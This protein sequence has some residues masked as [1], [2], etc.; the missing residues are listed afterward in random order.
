MVRGGGGGDT[1][2]ILRRQYHF[3][4]SFERGY[5]IKN[6]ENKSMH[7]GQLNIN[8]FTPFFLYSIISVMRSFKVFSL[9]SLRRLIFGL[10]FILLEPGRKQDSEYRS[11]A[12]RLVVYV[13]GT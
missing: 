5:F 8:Y 13:L 1:I 6:K 2:R 10:F 9:S 4:V 7:E 11:N 12:P 3:N